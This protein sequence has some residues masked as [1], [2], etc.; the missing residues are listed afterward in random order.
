[1]NQRRWIVPGAQKYSMPGYRFSNRWIVPGKHRI[2][3]LS[4]VEH[5]F[6][7][8]HTWIVPGTPKIYQLRIVVQSSTMNCS[9][10]APRIALESRFS[11][12]MNCS[13]SEAHKNI[14]F[15]DRFSKTMNCSRQAPR[16]YTWESFSKTMNCFRHTIFHLRIAF[17]RVTRRIVP[18]TQK[19]S[20]WGSFFKDDELF[21]A[22]DIFPL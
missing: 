10:H 16:I 8:N 14:P 22:H 9:R 12:A 15:Q 20:T 13:R 5:R 19:Y 18:G 11:N 21:Q 1:M 3:H 2:F 4:K 6:S 17:Q 7:M